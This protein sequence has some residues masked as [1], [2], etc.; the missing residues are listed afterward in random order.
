[1]KNG[2]VYRKF[3]LDLVNL[4]SVNNISLVFEKCMA[5]TNFNVIIRTLNSKK[6][7]EIVL[8][9]NY[10]QSV[11]E[12]V[13]MIPFSEEFEKVIKETKRCSRFNRI[14]LGPFERFESR[15]I[16]IEVSFTAVPNIICVKDI[17]KTPSSEIIP[18]IEGE[19]VGEFNHE[20]EDFQ[21]LN[22]SSLVFVKNIGDVSKY[23]KSDHNIYFYENN[24]IQ[25]DGESEKLKETNENRNYFIVCSSI[26]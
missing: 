14:S 22:L 11:F 19:Y 6:Q 15:Y 4:Y 7:W 26:D 12:Q 21:S 1:M 5:K 8:S 18:E 3:L 10:P 17:E 24:Q 23:V 13:A 2:K 9:R 25:L 20:L 16:E